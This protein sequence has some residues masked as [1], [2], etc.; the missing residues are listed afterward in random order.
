MDNNPELI[1]WFLSLP[2]AERLKKMQSMREFLERNNRQMLS[3]I[4]KFGTF[5]EKPVDIIQESEK[6]VQTN[7][8]LIER[9]EIM[10]RE[11]DA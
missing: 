10:Q 2:K 3:L 6:I 7:I 4:Q 8:K 11:T 5:E 1:H 9:I